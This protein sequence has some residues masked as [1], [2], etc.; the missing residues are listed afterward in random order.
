MPT[1]HRA[2]LGAAAATGSLPFYL[3][4][5]KRYWWLA[6]LIALGAVLIVDDV[7]YHATDGKYCVICKIIPE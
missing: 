5:P 2:Y 4:D 1:I 3:E 6:I 7:L